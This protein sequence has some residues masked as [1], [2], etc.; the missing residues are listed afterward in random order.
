V[1]IGAPKQR[2]AS[3]RNA[4]NPRHLWPIVFSTLYH[5]HLVFR[6]WCV[7]L[8]L[9]GGQLFESTRYRFL[10]GR[11]DAQREVPEH[12][13]TGSSTTCFVDP[14]AP[15]EAVMVR[16]FTGD[17]L[18]GVIPLFFFLLFGLVT[19]STV[20]DWFGGPTQP[21]QGTAADPR[22][23]GHADSSGDLLA[24]L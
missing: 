4:Q 11:S 15:A 23:A 16:G 9:F 5:R 6:V 2:W 17:M 3:R 20:R 24:R 21:K 8:R 12:H 1:A 10:G 22:P 13:R 18:F 7:A 19:Y 14:D